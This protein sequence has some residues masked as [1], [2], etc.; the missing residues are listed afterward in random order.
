MA[1]DYFKKPKLQLNSTNK[2]LLELLTN[3][4]TQL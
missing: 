2:F 3:M 1:H 4:L